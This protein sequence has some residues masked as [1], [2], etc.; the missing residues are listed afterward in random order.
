MNDPRAL[1]GEPLSLDLV[2]TEFAP[3]GT[4]VDLLATAESARSW[5]AAA[6]LTRDAGRG[7]H[8]RAKA[9]TV[10]GQGRATRAGHR[11][12]QRGP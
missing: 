7:E 9:D 11:A 1:P 3:D 10:S 2:N 12:A 6:G 8:R 4:L 5:A